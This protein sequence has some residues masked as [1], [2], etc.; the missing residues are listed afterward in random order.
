MVGMRRV[1]WVAAGVALIVVGFIAGTVI[2]LRGET[3]Q[4]VTAANVC[5]PVPIEGVRL[6]NNAL[7]PWGGLT[8]DSP[9]WIT[10]PG[11]P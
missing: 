8:F 5:S 3:A 6:L 2:D 7:L 11:G 1:T 10:Q 9:S 4:P